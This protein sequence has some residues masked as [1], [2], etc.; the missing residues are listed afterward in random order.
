MKVR[1]GSSAGFTL[2]ELIIVV[3]VIGILA[4]MVVPALRDV[5]IRA[6][7]AVL[8]TNLRAIRDVI[9][10]H[11]ADRGYYPPSLEALVEQ[12]YFRRIP[13]DPITGERDT[14]ELIYEDLDEDWFARDIDLGEFGEPGIIDVRSGSDLV[15]RD[16]TPY[17]EW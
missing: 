15:S 16:G 9:D 8:Q 13:R 4:A 2:L 12:G 10:Q 11:Y 5:P 14:W 17:S 3:A 1:T 6:Q 7:E